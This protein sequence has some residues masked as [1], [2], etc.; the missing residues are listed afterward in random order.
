MR[1]PKEAK[2]RYCGKRILWLNGPAGR[3]PVE[4]G[5]TPWRK[6]ADGEPHQTMFT[7]MGGILRGCA[8]TDDLHAEGYAHKFHFAGCRRPASRPRRN[9][10]R[11]GMR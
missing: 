4:A 3:F 1:E 8:E 5:L 6:A 9:D 10:T 2:C 11:P 7:N